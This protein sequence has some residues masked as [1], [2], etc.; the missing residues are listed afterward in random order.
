MNILLVTMEMNMGGAETHVLELAKALKNR[1]HNV[2]V[3]SAGGKL[4]DELEKS[5]VKHIYAPLKDKK[6]NHII[7]SMKTIK[8]AIKINNIDVVHAHAR[9]FVVLFAKKQK[10][11]LL[12]LYTEFIDLIFY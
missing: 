6:I 9:I 11:I 10:H 1:K 3:I 7:T 12:R 5:G 4:V 8:K 2:F